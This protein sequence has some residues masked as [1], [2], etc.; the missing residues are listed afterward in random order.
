VVSPWA[1]SQARQSAAVGAWNSVMDTI[2]L[3]K[4]LTN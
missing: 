1:A 4:V 2:L 3:A